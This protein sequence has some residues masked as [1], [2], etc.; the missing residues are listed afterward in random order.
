[1]YMALIPL[2]ATRLGQ[3]TIYK[4]TTIMCKTGTIRTC[5]SS[6]YVK[7]RDVGN[8]FS[9]IMDRIVSI[10]GLVGLVS[11]DVIYRKGNIEYLREKQ[12]NLLKSP[13]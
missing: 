7:L 2:P 13:L 8:I 3:Y 6:Y 4:I 5:V 9:R 10:T 1:M 11:Y 12:K